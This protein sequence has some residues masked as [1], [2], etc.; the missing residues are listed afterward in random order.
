M[1]R[2][3]GLLIIISLVFL[4]TSVF[5]AS[6]PTFSEDE[7]VIIDEV[8]SGDTLYQQNENEKF[9]PASTTKLMTALVAVENGNLTDIVTIGYEI[10]YI[11][12]DSSVADLQEEETMTLKDLIYGLLLP[13]GNDAA[14]TIAVS[15][16]RKIAAD[17]TLSS[18]DAE[19]VFI[20]V[21]NEKAKELEMTNSHFA[22]TH[23]L[24]N[25]D[26]YSTPEDMLKLAKVAFSNDIIREITRTQIFDLQ[27][28]LATHQ[29]Y[30]TNLMLYPNFD[31]LPNDYKE[32]HQLEGENDLFNSY[33]TS[34]KTG[35][36][37]EAGKCLI[38]EG[39]SNG[40]NVIGVVMKSEKDTIF[41][42]VNQSINTI[43]KDY[44]FLE[45][46][47]DDNFL[48][49]IKIGNNHIFDGSS[50]DIETKQP[51]ISLIPNGEKENYSIKIK[52]D[53]NLVIELSTG[54]EVLKAIHQDD[55]LG[56]VE[57]YQGDLILEAEPVYAMNNMAVRGF[58]DYL[59]IYWY[60]TIGIIILI[61][62]MLRILY[63]DF[64]RKNRIKYRKI[65]IKN[66][67]DKN[68][69]IKKRRR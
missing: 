63:V 54:T 50:L 35:Y 14:K 11:A 2:K 16:G 12:S 36:T 22:N 25:D 61:V 51:L 19:D 56:E 57:V 4:T 58:F 65:K 13:S 52:W 46:T 53:P 66:K 49:S 59:L 60:I 33:A 30:N 43:I 31:K 55:L 47:G 9:Y 24:H 41:E 44:E 68:K 1:K 64:M 32:M 40:K 3:I 21:M 45:W 23:G 69:A 17:D 37:E 38:F 6:F 18:D 26:H 42:D 48:T 20:D 8:N 39:E 67:N 62:G 10:N 29:W 7:G 5:G 15:I 34:G 28:N 27:T